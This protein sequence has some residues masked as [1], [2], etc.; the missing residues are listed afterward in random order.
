MTPN[1]VRERYQNLV[2]KKSFF[3]TFCC[4]WGLIWYIVTPTVFLFI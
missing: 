2:V 4:F 1:I 3:L